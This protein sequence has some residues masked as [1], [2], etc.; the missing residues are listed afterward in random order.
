MILFFIFCLF[1]QIRE[2]AGA[3]ELKFGLHVEHFVA[4][5]KTKDL[6]EF[7]PQ[8]NIHRKF[9]FGL[10]F[11]LWERSRCIFSVKYY[12]DAKHFHNSS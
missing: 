7:T 9:T 10:H 2:L 3:A 5:K 4:R 12:V 6:S 1:A 11:R 8:L